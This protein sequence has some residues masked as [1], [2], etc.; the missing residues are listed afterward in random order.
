MPRSTALTPSSPEAPSP[1]SSSPPVSP[2]G[3]PPPS[4]SSPLQ[5]VP[6]PPASPEWQL[7]AREYVQAK[8]IEG[9]PPLPPPS[10]QWQL[11]A[12]EYCRMHVEPLNV[13]I[14]AISAPEDLPPPSVPQYLPLAERLRVARR[15]IRE[16][17]QHLHSAIQR[18]ENEFSG[19]GSTPGRRIQELYDEL[20]QWDSDMQQLIRIDDENDRQR[21]E[22][23][24]LIQALVAA[25][26]QLKQY[27][28]LSPRSVI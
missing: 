19:D 15:K 18:C 21:V 24:D 6:L 9:Y 13:P 10:P 28:L 14:A 17:R 16:Q 11:E 1:R 23:Q 7:A 4:A 20:S 5:S 27:V 25:L 26:L 3:P 2:S 12:I 22:I 8:V